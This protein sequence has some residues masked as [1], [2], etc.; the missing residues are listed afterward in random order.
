MSTRI[1]RRVISCV[2]RL[3]RQS[4]VL[5]SSLTLRQPSPV[6]G[7]T[8]GSLT[9]LPPFVELL[10]CAFKLQ[11]NFPQYHPPRSSTSQQLRTVFQ[12]PETFLPWRLRTDDLMSGMLLRWLMPRCV[13]VRP[14]LHRRYLVYLKFAL[15]GPVQGAQVKY[16]PSDNMCLQ[17]HRESRYLSRHP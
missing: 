10:F 4:S 1:A 15:S 9:R 2:R 14:S 13:N 17:Y 7:A 6:R 12:L 8:C 11:V 3:I 5:T 16:K